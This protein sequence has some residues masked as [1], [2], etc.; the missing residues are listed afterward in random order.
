MT[1][2]TFLSTIKYEESDES[3]NK[4]CVPACAVKS[5][6]FKNGSF[7]FVRLKNCEVNKDFA[8]VAVL[9][10]RFCK[11]QL[12]EGPLGEDEGYVMDCGDVY[13]NRALCYNL[14]LP[15][16]CLN[17]LFKATLTL[18]ALEP[19]FLN[20][21][22]H[23]PFEMPLVQPA[24]TVLLTLAV[25][26]AYKR[27]APLIFSLSPSRRINRG[28]ITMYL[29][30]RYVKVGEMIFADWYGGSEEVLFV[31]DVKGSLSTP[32][33]RLQECSFL[34]KESTEFNYL[35]GEET[36]EY[37]STCQ[38]N[39]KGLKTSAVHPLLIVCR[40]FP[41]HTSFVNSV[42]TFIRNGLS[43][44]YLQDCK[45]AN[46]APSRSLCVYGETGVGK[47]SLIKTIAENYGV[48][49]LLLE[50]SLFIAGGDES[51]QGKLKELFNFIRNSNACIIVIDTLESLLP[52]QTNFVESSVESRLKKTFY[53]FLDGLSINYDLR[54]LLIAICPS[55]SACDS[56]LDAYGRFDT[57]LCI[58]PPDYD[59]RKAILSRLFENFAFSVSEKGELLRWLLRFTSGYTPAHLQHLCKV[60]LSFA[61]KRTAEPTKNSLV[62]GR[63]EFEKALQ[64]VPP[65]ALAEFQ[66][67][68]PQLTFRELAGISH[69][70]EMLNSHIVL[71]WENQSLLRKLGGTIPTGLLLNGKPGTGKT[72][73]ALALAN[74]LQLKVVRVD[75]SSVRSKF[76]GES[77]KILSKI[78]TRCRLAAPCVLLLD[79]IDVL[80]LKRAADGDQSADRLLSCLLTEMDGI[81]GN[82]VAPESVLVVATTDRPEVLDPAL[83]RPGRLE[84]H[85]EVPLPDKRAR[86]EILEAK[87]LHTPSNLTLDIFREAVDATAGCSGAD[88]ENL[89]REA[90]MTGLREDIHMPALEDCHM[91]TSLEE[92][93]RRLQASR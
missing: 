74:L 26:L 86:G 76:V 82:S 38:Q 54:V 39:I 57:V 44:Q 67:K 15:P 87:L 43:T 90:V 1:P 29:C 63:F 28:L 47:S 80:G 62:V 89:C 69:V 93:R 68:I 65:P 58:S 41:G 22:Q 64:L 92:L 5:Y 21:L 10:V 6:N 16:S 73:I 83:L 81:F 37:I 33:D 35:T 19:T 42:L 50:G 61:V 48:P 52:N 70:Y 9:Q 55:L 72:S 88:L 31:I 56:G 60:A 23:F 7:A 46:L 12:S 17:P 14:S 4:L 59:Q 40:K 85:I 51:A 3:Y 20:N 13:I 34:I 84:V 78:F 30:H 91:R 32:C 75:C 24:H 25:R 45:A 71:P 77:E 53:K 2:F 49:Y 11:S 27:D 8:A 18:R 66:P 36:M 79:Q